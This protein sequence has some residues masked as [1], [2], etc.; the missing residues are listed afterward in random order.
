MAVVGGI[1]ELVLQ[2]IVADGVVAL[3]ELEPTIV[4]L[5]ER[6]GYSEIPPD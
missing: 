1:G 4:E 6:V 3:P 5:I 2:R